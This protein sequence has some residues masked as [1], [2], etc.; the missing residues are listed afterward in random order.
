MHYASRLAGNGSARGV[1]HRAL[2]GEH[3]RSGLGRGELALI[4]ALLP[5]AARGQPGRPDLGGQG[6]GPDPQP[7]IQGADLGRP[8]LPQ[9]HR[10]GG[11][12]HRGGGGEQ[13][14]QPQPQ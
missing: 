9:E 11:R 14:R 1:Q 3:L 4:L 13:Q 7:G 2:P 10:P 5:G 12:D 6:I 8:Q